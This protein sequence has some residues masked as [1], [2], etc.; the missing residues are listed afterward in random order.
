MRHT[1]CVLNTH[2]Y[3]QNTEHETQGPKIAVAVTDHKT[4]TKNIQH[5]LRHNIAADAHTLHF[6]C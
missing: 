3:A 5:V 2:V 4:T 6:L 1:L